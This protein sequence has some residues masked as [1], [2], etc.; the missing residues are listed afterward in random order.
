MLKVVQIWWK[1]PC[2]RE[3]S[4][5]TKVC[6]DPLV[7][8]VSFG[9]LIGKFKDKEGMEYYKICHKLAVDGSE[10]NDD[11]I[12]IPLGCVT[13]VVEMTEVGDKDAKEKIDFMVF[14]LG[15]QGGKKDE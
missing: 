5:A 8:L 15:D 4:T 7:S 12:A 11:W 9:I 6:V 14:T 2:Q 3:N 10:N 13:R 1:D